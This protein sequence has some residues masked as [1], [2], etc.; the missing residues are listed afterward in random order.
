MLEETNHLFTI[1][2][3]CRQDVPTIMSLIQELAAYENLADSVT[4]NAEALERH[5]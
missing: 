1:R 4:G 3:A 2:F 5:L